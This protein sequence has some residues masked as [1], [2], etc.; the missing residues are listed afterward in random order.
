MLINMTTVVENLG[1]AGRIAIFRPR[2]ITNDQWWASKWRSNLIEWLQKLEK[3]VGKSK[4]LT[5]FGFSQLSGSYCIAQLRFLQSTHVRIR[6]A[7]V[8]FFSEQSEPFPFKYSGSNPV[9]GHF[10]F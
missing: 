5:D 1:E 4:N 7:A 10:S 6:F 9:A 3:I 8:N 2:Y